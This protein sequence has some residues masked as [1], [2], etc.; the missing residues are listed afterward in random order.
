M[1]LDAV[2]ALWDQ[3]VE[4]RADSAAD[5]R[6]FYADPVPVNGTSMM[7]AGQ[8]PHPGRRGLRSRTAAPNWCIGWRPP[9]DW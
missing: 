3:P 5:F 1:N 7:T 6:R 8:W 4:D 2:L 9:G